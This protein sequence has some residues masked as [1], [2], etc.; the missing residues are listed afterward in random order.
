MDF[1]GAGVALVIGADE[2]VLA[3]ILVSAAGAEIQL[4]SAVGAVEKAGEYAG[5]SCF[6]RPAFVLPQFL[7]PFPLS[8]LNDGGLGVL[9]N[10]LVL[11]RVFHPLFEFQR[12]GIGLEVHGTARVLPPLQ[13]S[14]HG[15]GIPTV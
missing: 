8:L 15:V 6:C 10:P 4:C 2:M 11:N 12:L 3:V 14:K 5:S 1:A 7:H 13:N 9:K